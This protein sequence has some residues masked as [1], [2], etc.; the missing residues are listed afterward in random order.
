MS[1]P[2]YVYKWQESKLID[3]SALKQHLADGWVESPALTT[4]PKAEVAEPVKVK[5]VKKD[6][7]EPAHTDVV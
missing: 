5:R 2:T 3:S 1:F 7:S 6:D 4:E